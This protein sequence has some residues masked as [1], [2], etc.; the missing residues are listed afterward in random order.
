MS[1]STPQVCKIVV[2]LSLLFWAVQTHGDI[3]I[4]DSITEYAGMQGSN[5]WYYGYWQKTGDADGVYDDGEFVPMPRYGAIHFQGSLAW[6]ISA[7]YWTGLTA[8]GGHPNGVVTS[9][10]RSPVEQWAIRR[11]VSPVAGGIIVTGL[12]AKFNT[13]GGDGIVGM[14]LVDGTA[15]FTRQIGGND[16]V[17]VNYS[18]QT[19][20]NIGSV[21]DFIITPG[22]A[23][24]DS[25]DGTRFSGTIIL[26]EP[27]PS[28]LRLN[29]VERLSKSSIRISITNRPSTVFLFQL[30]SDL[31][32]WVT[33]ATNTLPVPIVRYVD[34]NVLS[35]SS[36][37]YRVEAKSP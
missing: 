19:T 1:N 6:D 30:S 4:A 35:S 32:S 14:I 23:G 25:I 29:P 11:W 8:I 31:A 16:G 33:V 18:V 34:T 24:Q 15:V 2:L 12:L 5:H 37:F 21:V 9:G 7:N 10:G 17:G 3:I 20:V 28:P 36:R 26:R 27:V 22:P 13:A